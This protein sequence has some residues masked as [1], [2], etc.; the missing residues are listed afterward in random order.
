MQQMSCTSHGVGSSGVMRLCIVAPLLLVAILMNGCLGNQYVEAYDFADDP[1]RSDQSLCFDYMVTD[2]TDSQSIDISVCYNR[3]IAP[4]SLPL[5]IKATDKQSNYYWVDT[6]NIP[7]DGDISQHGDEVIVS[8]FPN[9]TQVNVNYR[10]GIRYPHP[11]VRSLSIRQ[12]TDRDTLTGIIS[13]S[14]M[15]TGG[16]NH[17]NH[18]D[19]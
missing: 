7:T 13:V 12:L 5:E 19:K 16:R 18:N 9:Y 15:A 11:G 3:R 14:I 10:R 6:I 1:W 2:T 4:K 8:Q 17:I